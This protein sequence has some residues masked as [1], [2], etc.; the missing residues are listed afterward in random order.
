MWT[1]TEY[2]KHCH[3]QNNPAGLR[4]CYIPSETCGNTSH[5]MHAILGNDFFLTISY[6]HTAC[7]K[8][9]QNAILILF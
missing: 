9:S 8:H 4:L 6:Q 3:N 2:D 7:K 1:Q 5:G